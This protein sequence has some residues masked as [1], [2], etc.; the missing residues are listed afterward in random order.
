MANKLTSIGKD[1]AITLAKTGWWKTK[2]SEEIV[3]FQLFTEELAM[4]FGDFHGAVE[5]ALGRPVWTHE[6]AQLESLQ[7]EFLG[8][9]PAPT[10]IEILEMIPK[11]KRIVVEI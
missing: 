7:L 2:T 5:A 8:E 11:E 4:D 1:K 10:M 6:F 3:R 9:K